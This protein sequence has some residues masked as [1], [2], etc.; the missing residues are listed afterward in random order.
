M[1]R[2]TVIAVTIGIAL[3]LTGFALATHTTEIEKIV[4]P[5]T[6]VIGDETVTGE[7]TITDTDVLP[8]ETITGP[9]TTITDT[10][11]TTVTVTEP[12]PT[13]TT[14]PT[15]PGDLV[16]TTENYWNEVENKQAWTWDECKVGTVIE[17]TNEEWACREPIANYGPLP[18]KVVS[19]WSIPNPSGSPNIA[20]SINSGCTA[21]AGT[22]INLIPDVQGVSGGQISDAFKTRQVPGPQNIRLTGRLGCGDRLAADH[23]DGVQLQGGREIAFVNMDVGGDYEAGEANCQGAGGAFFW[24]IN[25]TLAVILGGTYIGCNHALDVHS[26]EAALGSGVRNAKFRSGRN[27]GN[28]GPAGLCERA[29]GTPFFTSPPCLNTGNLNFFD[30]NVCQRWN[31]TAWINQ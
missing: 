17:V 25:E 15:P 23:Q 2:I 12:P 26:G 21:S 6:L 13:T 28:G 8:H 11:I 18:I 22:A 29:D 4:L 7:T 19:R 24:S 31:G 27:S 5:W 16:C 1:K 9:T 3:G 10:T 14:E 20:I 30:N